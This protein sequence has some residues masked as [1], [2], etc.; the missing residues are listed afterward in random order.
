MEGSVDFGNG[1]LRLHETIVYNGMSCEFCAH[2]FAEKRMQ[3]RALCPRLGLPCAPSRCDVS[4]AGDH[5][6]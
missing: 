5:K 2:G 4:A 1:G 3:Q 6:G